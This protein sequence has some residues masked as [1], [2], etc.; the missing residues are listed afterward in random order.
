VKSIVSD[1]GAV[2]TGKTPSTKDEDNFGDEVP[3]IKT[4][5]M[6][7]SSI[8]TFPEEFLSE[9]GAKSQPK[10]FLPPYSILVAC[11]GAKLGVV[12]FNRN[13]AQTNQQINA[14]IPK[15][16]FLRCFSYF[17]LESFKP[18][19][20]SIGGGATMPNVNKSKF[21]TLDYFLPT[22]SLLEM[23]E[24]YAQSNFE[25]MAQL[26]EMNKKLK[27]ARDILL[28]RLMNGELAV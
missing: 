13:V 2:I 22:K 1:L 10:K 7:I 9:K 27:E 3:F 26:I 5:D 28:P 19:L 25:Q 24:S 4:P 12:T 16:D 14:V 21:S 18:R 8:V 23:F 11:I 15:K 17:L 6:H 20:Q